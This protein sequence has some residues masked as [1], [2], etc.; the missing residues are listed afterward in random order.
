MLRKKQRSSSA[1]TEKF[2]T[3]NREVHKQLTEKFSS[4]A[5]TSHVE[6]KCPISITIHLEF[7][8]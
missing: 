3:I 5:I 8:C 4:I 2:I 7:K 1:C 6:F